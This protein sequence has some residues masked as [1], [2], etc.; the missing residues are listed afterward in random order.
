[1]GW[2]AR[3]IPGWRGD[4]SLR[5]FYQG[6]LHPEMIN[7]IA[8]YKASATGGTDYARALRASLEYLLEHRPA[9]VGQWWSLT[10]YSFDSEE[11]LYRYLQDLH[12]Y[13][14][15]DRAEEPIAP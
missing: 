1:M 6:A 7:D 10:R 5:N 12:A 13:F 15:G 8:L 14:Y 3:D 4:R 9:S 11:E 2:T